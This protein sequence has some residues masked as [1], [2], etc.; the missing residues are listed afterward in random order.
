MR[1]P[2]SY[3]YDFSKFHNPE[4]STLCIPIGRYGSVLVLV[5]KVKRRNQELLQIVDSDSITEQNIVQEAVSSVW[6][7]SHYTE[8]VRSPCQQMATILLLFITF[9]PSVDYGESVLADKFHLKIHI[10]GYFFLGTHT[11][12]FRMWMS[13]TEL[14]KI[15][16]K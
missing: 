16:P 7:S 2:N 14:D 6:C 4:W 8:Y 5:Q 3:T 10:K 12:K 1:Y 9:K 13:T 11:F 15:F